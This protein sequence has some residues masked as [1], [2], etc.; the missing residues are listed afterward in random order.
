MIQ[1]HL[2]GQDVNFQVCININ[3]QCHKY[4][5]YIM[6]LT[7]TIGLLQERNIYVGAHVCLIYADRLVIDLSFIVYTSIGVAQWSSE[8]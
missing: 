3:F 5:N 4:E 2:E 6:T 7:S 1:C 8:I